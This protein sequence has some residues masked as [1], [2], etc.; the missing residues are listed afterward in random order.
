MRVLATDLHNY[1][2]KQVTVEGWV[3]SRRDH[4]GLIFIDLR[5]HTGIIQLVITPETQ[6]AFALAESV[7]DEYV[8]KATGKKSSTDVPNFTVS[9]VII[10]MITVSPKS[11]PQ[12]LPILPPKEHAIFSSHQDYIQAN[13][14]PYLKPPSNL[15]NSSW[16]VDL[17]NT[18]RSPLASAT[19]TLAPTVFM[20]IFIN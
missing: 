6:D 1:L 14:T 5:D 15:S 2:K 17:T 12:F 19:K 11:P 16:L 4:G 7:R 10:C 3:N 13:S 18:S 8:L 20:A 9:F